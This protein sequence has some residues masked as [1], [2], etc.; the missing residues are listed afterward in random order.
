MKVVG[1]P[2]KRRHT[3][4]SDIQNILVPQCSGFSHAATSETVMSQYSDENDDSDD[5]II[6]P[7]YSPR[8]EDISNHS[9]PDFMNIVENHYSQESSSDSNSELDEVV[10]SESEI[11]KREGENTP[12]VY[13]F[14][15][16]TTI[17]SK[18]K[19]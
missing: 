9:D 13:K 6:D 15:I 1:S 18:R 19:H 2:C 7:N 5:T 4:N 12:Q 8:M 11:W 17:W 16:S 14:N 3:A 10:V